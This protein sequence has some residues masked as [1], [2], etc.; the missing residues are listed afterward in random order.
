MVTSRTSQLISEAM[1]N[2]PLFSG[3]EEV[4][5]VLIKKGADVNLTV[6]NDWTV[7]HSAILSGELKNKPLNERR[8]YSKIN[9]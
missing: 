2:I 8:L 7:L 3:H 4:L 9:C 5:E 1:K 6:S